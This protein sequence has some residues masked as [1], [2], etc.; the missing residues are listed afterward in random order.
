MVD[1][2]RFSI[3]CGE[4]HRIVDEHLSTITDVAS[5]IHIEKI[6]P[7]VIESTHPY[8]IISTLIISLIYVIFSICSQIP[9]LAPICVT[10]AFY[11][12]VNYIMHST[13]FSSCFVI[14]LKRISSRRHCL[15]CFRLSK[16]YYT[17]TNRKQNAFK[18]LK[19][20]I[21]TFFNVNAFWKK[22]FANA[23]CSISLAFLI[24]SIWSGLSIDTRLYEDKLLPRDATPLRSYMQSQI[25]EFDV[26]PVIMFTIPKVL[27]YKTKDV[28]NSI[29]TLLEQ[30]INETRTNTFQLLWLN[31]ENITAIEMS[32]EPLHFRMTPLSEN[33]L[34]VSQEQNYSTIV[35]SRFYCQ[36]N[37][38]QGNIAIHRIDDYTLFI[39][40]EH[41]QGCYPK[42]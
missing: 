28:Q 1:C 36:T 22:L 41:N 10:L 23:L 14:T 4:Y 8:F 16:D 18:A 17:K 25:D 11:A 40:D 24:S 38:I 20:K 7:S 29:S 32:N 19:L 35:A 15:F 12:F 27:D 37:S 31:Y 9:A 5:H 13:F 2:A 34:V 21:K 30:C 3:L 39:F 42:L 33:D 6:L 26:G